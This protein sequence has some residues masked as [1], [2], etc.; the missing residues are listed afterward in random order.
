MDFAVATVALAGNPRNGRGVK[1]VVRFLLLLLARRGTE[2]GNF[3]ADQ[4]DLELIGHRRV[5][6]KPLDK[7]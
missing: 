5:I 4:L 1:S 6:P 7:L 3:V 2:R